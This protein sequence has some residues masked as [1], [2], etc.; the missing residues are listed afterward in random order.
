MSH[1]LIDWKDDEPKTTFEFGVHGIIRRLT[2]GSNQAGLQCSL[3]A[4]LCPPPGDRD[5]P[6]VQIQLSFNH[7]A[8]YGCSSTLDG[9]MHPLHEVVC[10]SGGLGQLTQVRAATVL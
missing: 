3:R 6:D 1:T 4:V 5:D 8:T 2:A 10:M 9:S 7:T